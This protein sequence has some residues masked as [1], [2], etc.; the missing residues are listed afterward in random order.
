MDVEQVLW[1]V[2]AGCQR[3]GWRSEQPPQ[4]LGFLLNYGLFGVLSVQVYTYYE[5]FP[6][7]QWHLKLLVYGLYVVE[8]LQSILVTS[9]AFEKFAYGFGDLGELNKM[10]LLWLDCCIIDGA[11]AFCVQVYF[12]HRL[13]LLSKS[14]ILSGIILFM[15]LAQFAGA[16]ATGILAEA[17]GLFSLIRERC[18][19]AAVFWLGGSAACDIVIAIAMTWALSRYQSRFQESGDVVKRLIRL[20]METGSLTATVAFV[21][22]V[23]YLSYPDNAY[24][25]TPA[26]ALA[27][28]YSNSLMVVMNSRPGAQR[29]QPTETI[30]ESPRSSKSSLELTPSV[31]R[32]SAIR[33]KH[34]SFTPTTSLPIATSGSGHGHDDMS[35]VSQSTV[36]PMDPHRRPNPTIV[37]HSLL[38]RQLSSRTGSTWADTAVSPVDS[39]KN[40]PSTIG[41]SEVA[42]NRF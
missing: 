11:V 2:F 24:H 23:L 22:L 35:I 19:E 27:K 33:S 1:C 31:Q 29:N 39:Y 20:S 30:T 16:V 7:D 18:F 28:L 15:A 12:A 21:D 37:S 17:A 38:S 41:S 14:K 32:N 25:I 10:N 3:D 8:A 36:P 6:S 4:L 5:Y 13:Y 40:R 42:P 9:D 34:S 26:L